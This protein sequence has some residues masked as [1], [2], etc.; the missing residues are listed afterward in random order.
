M[1]VAELAGIVSQ[2]AKRS[3]NF[4][5]VPLHDPDFVV[6]SI[7]DVKI[8]LIGGEVEVER[9]AGPE[10]LWR[11]QPF[12]DELAILM[13]DLHPVAVAVADVEQAIFRESNTVH[14]D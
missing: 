11:D 12:L 5:R 1:D 7:R 13:K 14:G 3:D 6:G 2:L 10:R 4:H 8:S 9:C